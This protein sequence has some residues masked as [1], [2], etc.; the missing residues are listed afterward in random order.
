MI[1]EVET[2]YGA[3]QQDG[4]PLPDDDKPD[5]VTLHERAEQ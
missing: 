4:N 2:P 3:S 5:N 1:I